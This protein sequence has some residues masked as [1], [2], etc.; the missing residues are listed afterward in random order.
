MDGKRGDRRKFRKTLFCPHTSTIH[1]RNRLS[2][3]LWCGACPHAGEFKLD[4]TREA[5]P[6]TPATFMQSSI[7]ANEGEQSTLSK[8]STS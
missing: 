6:S 8:R 2:A 4:F 7:E 1:P 5:Q 3:S